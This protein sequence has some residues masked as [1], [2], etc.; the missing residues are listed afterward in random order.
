M[1]LQAPPSTH[2]V[3]TVRM[4]LTGLQWLLQGPL[5]TVF[6]LLSLEIRGLWQDN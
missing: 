2:V 1:M 6:L 4:R 5:N 3:G